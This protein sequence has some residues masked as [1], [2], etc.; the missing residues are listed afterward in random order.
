MLTIPDSEDDLSVFSQD[1]RT[2]LL[3]ETAV[4]PV[5]IMLARIIRDGWPDDFGQVPNC[6]RTFWSY[7]DELGT[8]N[9]IVFKG[10]Q[11]VVPKALQE[12]ILRQLHTSHMGIEKTRRLARDCVY[13][14]GINKDIENIVK[15]CQACQ[16]N[17]DQQQKEPLEP[18]EV[19]P[20][21]WTKLA[22]DLFHLD[23]TDFLLITDYHSKFPVIRRMHSTTSTAVTTVMKEAFSM[24]G[25]PTE[26]VSDN[27]PQFSGK[28]FQEM[29]AKWNIKHTTSSPRYP[30]SN[31]LAERMVR[32]VKSMIKKCRQTGQDLLE[33]LLHLRATPQA[34]LPSPAEL[35]YGR[36]VKTTLPGRSY[37]YPHND[38]MHDQIQHRR[39]KMKHDHDK[40]AGKE[41]P[42]LT[43]G[44]RVRMLDTDDNTWIP[45]KVSRVCEAP[46]S[47]EVTTPNG[48]TLRR[49][50]SHLREMFTSQPKSDTS[51][52]SLDPRR[53]DLEDEEAKET[54]NQTPHMHTS[55][56]TP[57]S[58]SDRH[59]YTT[60]YGR[61]IHRPVRYRNHT[62]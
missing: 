32:T 36:K 49:N 11:V 52:A 58:Q 41:L 39:E 2:Q 45:A 17:Q 22:A 24:F 9:G 13:W 35:M 30:R 7:R 6:L 1:K 20:T 5:M 37:G 60:R 12:D 34:D 4:D 18:H 27:G 48:R 55:D 59:T 47:Y 50:R 19:P 51:S 14:P 43:V 25:V 28:P 54:D 40:H 3:I 44:Q 33:A 38:N 15:T 26:V 62:H 8:V 56:R 53:L 31:G 16:E 42:K 29:C 23:G 61:Q 21:P 57:N 46:R 10:R